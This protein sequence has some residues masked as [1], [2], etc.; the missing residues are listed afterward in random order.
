MAKST[1]TA[2]E[3]T[4]ATTSGTVFEHL[5]KVKQKLS[6]IQKV[7]D[8][9]YKTPGRVDTNGISLDVK[10]ETKVENLVAAYAGIKS[11]ATAIE[12]AYADLGI[13][14][15]KVV[16]VNDGTVDEWKSDIMLRMNI[17]NNQDKLNELNKIKD[18][19]TE[20]MGKEEKAALLMQKLENL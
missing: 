7:T 19:L 11:K 14:T 2:T 6:E 1:K 17:I 16:K 13:T 15:H 20:L 18:G 3:T 10:T 12:G 8:S 9:V 5:E 4:L